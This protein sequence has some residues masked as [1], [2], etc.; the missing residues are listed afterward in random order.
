MGSNAKGFEFSKFA[1]PR[2]IGGIAIT[3]I[4]LWALSV[5]FSSPNGRS[6]TSLDAGR[7]DPVMATGTPRPAGET[8]PLDTR[9]SSAAATTS[10]PVE[11]PSLPK[12]PLTASRPDTLAIDHGSDGHIAAPATTTVRPDLPATAVV[13]PV[14]QP[15]PK[16][17][18]FTE[19]AIEP[20]RYELEDRWWGWRPNDL[21]N[22]TDNINNFQ[23]G[24][25]E[26]SRRTT[27]ALAER[28]SRTGTTASFDE[29]LEQA[30]NWYMVKASSYWFPSAESK[31]HDSLREMRA[32]LAKLKAGKAAFYTR[33]DNL[34]PLLA[35]FEDLLGSCDENLVKEAHENGSSVSFFLVDDYFY[36]AQ[37]VANSMATVLKAVHH[38]FNQTLE[39]RH[40]TELLHH[41]ILSCER[42]AAIDPWIVLDS[43]LSNIFANHRANMAAPISHARFYLGQLIKT[44]ST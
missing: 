26:V 9:D 38:D 2:I 44:L 18:A 32:Y 35:S 24:V 21:I 17:V 20:M 39:S 16:G 7:P 40:A 10:A 27:V 4:I 15:A 11:A 41:A 8:G 37:G 19:A 33:T 23:M 30:M 42:A 6:F 25:L 3:I 1:T 29:D 14:H 13:A 36:Y 22:L 43:N 28:I 12:H 34:I 31:Y 5:I